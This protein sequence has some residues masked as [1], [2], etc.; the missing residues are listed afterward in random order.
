MTALRTKTSLLFGC[1]AALGLAGAA[2]AEMMMNFDLALPSGANGARTVGNTAIVETTSAALGIDDTTFGGATFGIE[3]MLEAFVGSGVGTNPVIVVT[4]S[5]GLPSP[6]GVFSTTPR[7]DNENFNNNSQTLDGSRSDE[8]SVNGL[9]I[10]D[11]EANDSGFTEENFSVS[12]SDLNIVN[13]GNNDNLN[14]AFGARSDSGETFMSVP[15]GEVVLSESFTLTSPPD[16]LFLRSVQL[17]NQNG[18]SSF[19]IGGIGVQ[20]TQI[21]ATAIPEPA[22]TALICVGA[23]VV[24]GRR[25]RSWAED[26][27]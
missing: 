3:Y 25:R 13:G 2:N 4:D 24:L 9:R 11:F 21:D 10:I 20:V 26:A 23:A 19:S 15:T 6:F 16:Q 18:F 7:P 22:S 27:A 5:N 14:I 17:E 8:I 1:T 12:F